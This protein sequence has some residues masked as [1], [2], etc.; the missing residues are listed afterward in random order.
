MVILNVVS[1]TLE[2]IIKVHLK[3]CGDDWRA[4]RFCRIISDA[5]ILKGFLASHH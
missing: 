1:K 5:K 4:L 2:D 3:V